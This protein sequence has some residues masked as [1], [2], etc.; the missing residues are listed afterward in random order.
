MNFRPYRYALELPIRYRRAGDPVWSE[1][2]TANISRSG[3][4]FR[5][6]QALGLDTQIEICIPLS[7]A[8]A[9]PA[10]ADLVCGARIVRSLSPELDDSVTLAAAF[11]DYRFDEPLAW[12]RQGSHT[13]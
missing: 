7:A 9:V 12:M 1:G 4:L 5:G 8:T 2:R 10:A 13:C 3:V 6:Q 11:S